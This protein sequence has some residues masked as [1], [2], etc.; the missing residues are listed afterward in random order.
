MG[1][2]SGIIKMRLNVE[3]IQHVEGLLGLFWVI[4]F[5][6]ICNITYSAT[7]FVVVM[8]RILILKS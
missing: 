3:Q 2:G 5:F 8:F 1:R 6:G 7:M 4:S